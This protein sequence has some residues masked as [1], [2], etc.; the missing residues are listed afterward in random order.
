MNMLLCSMQPKSQSQASPRQLGTRAGIFRFAVICLMLCT[1]ACMCSAPLP[2]FLAEGCLSTLTQYIP[3][4]ASIIGFMMAFNN[5]NQKQ[6]CR[7]NQKALPLSRSSR[8]DAQT[9]ILCMKACICTLGPLRAQILLLLML[10]WLVFQATSHI[11]GL[12]D[13]I[14]LIASEP[15]KPIMAIPDSCKVYARS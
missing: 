3:W 10:L 14:V 2:A 4:Y 1:Y 5:V 9:P 7:R 13:H 15:A 12:R 6:V 11:M 8:S